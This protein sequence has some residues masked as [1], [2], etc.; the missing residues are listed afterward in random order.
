MLKYE[1]KKENSEINEKSNKEICIYIITKLI[2]EE[3]N[4]KFGITFLFLKLDVFILFENLRLKILK[5]NQSIGIS[6]NNL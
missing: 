4:Y 5:A 2:K 1:I 6:L 3:T